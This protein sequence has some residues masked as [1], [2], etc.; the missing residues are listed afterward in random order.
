VDTGINR[1]GIK[2]E[3]AIECAIQIHTNP[4]FKLVGVM[5]HLCCAFMKNKKYTQQQYTKFKELKKQLQDM[6][7]RPEWFHISNSGGILNYSNKDFNMVRSAHAVFGLL[8]HKHI[9]PALSLT[10]KI[11][12]LKVISKGEGIGYDRTYIAKHSMRIG[13]VPIGYADV[14][15]YTK[16][17]EICVYV[18]GTRRNVLGLISMDQIVIESLPTDKVGNEVELFG[19]HQTIYDFV[20]HDTSKHVVSIISHLGNRINRIYA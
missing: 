12:Q 1:N 5:T 7:I 11:I 2:Y 19:K 16:P 18:N 4:K 8:H 20:K 9:L 3:N 17:G 15:P 13:I 10:S 14:L 6:S